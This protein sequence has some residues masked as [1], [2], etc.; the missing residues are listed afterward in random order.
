VA[1]T[2]LFFFAISQFKS[3]I[4]KEKNISELVVTGPGCIV[5]HFGP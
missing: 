4:L 3:V 2:R 5:V 1:E